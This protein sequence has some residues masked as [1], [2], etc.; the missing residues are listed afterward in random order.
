MTLSK[1]TENG[2][3]TSFIEKCKI[4]M[5]FSLIFKKNIQLPISKQ[6]GH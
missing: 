5:D 2:I 1:I 4:V 6:V 3:R